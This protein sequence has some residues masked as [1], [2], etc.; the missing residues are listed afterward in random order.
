MKTIAD[1]LKQDNSHYYI[2]GHTDD[3][4]SF[5]HNMKLSAG[6]AEATVKA[7]VKNYGIKNSRLL[8]H[9]AGPLSPASTNTSAVGKKLNRR[10]E[11][12]K[13]LTK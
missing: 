13:R 12:V 6:R 1:Y 9:G 4:G 2:V 10:V 3:S 7:L 11:I 5:N 8:S